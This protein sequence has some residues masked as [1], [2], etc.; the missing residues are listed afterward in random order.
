MNSSL[1]NK[2]ELSEYMNCSIGKIDILM[3]KGLKYVKFGR[4]VRFRKEDI[5]EYLENKVRHNMIE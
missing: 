2:K 1:L 3:N 4:N 5:Y